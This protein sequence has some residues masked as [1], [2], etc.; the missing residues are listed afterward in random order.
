MENESEKPFDE[1]RG[2]EK[3]NYELAVLLDNETAE[4]AIADFL[5]KNQAEVYQKEGPKTVNLAYPIK[6]HASAALVVYCFSAPTEV[7][8]TLKED[9]KMQPNVLRSLLITPPVL[10]SKKIVV[11]ESRP[12]SVDIKPPRTE[13][14][15]NEALEETLEKI[16]QWT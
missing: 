4:P 9:L 10:K 12:I 7:V 3:R 5:A 11:R 1:A 15:T 6:K 14:V 13:A 16:L 2:K 8:P